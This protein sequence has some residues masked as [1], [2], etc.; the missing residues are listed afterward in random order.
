MADDLH[1]F[2]V[3]TDQSNEAE[4]K[5][6]LHL[7]TLLLPKGNRDTVEVL[8]V[9]L[10]WVASFAHVDEETGN[11]MDLHNLATVISPNIFRSYATKGNDN[12][13]VESFEGIRVC[14][15]LLIYQ[16]EF[17]LVPE[18]F[19]P[20]IRDV[21]FFVNYAELPSKEFLK[22]CDQ[23]L[24]V[25]GGSN[26]NSN[27]RSAGTSQ[28][29]LTSPI[30]GSA[31]F[32][33]SASMSSMGSESSR[34]TSQKSDP[35]MSSRGR[36]LVEAAPVARAPAN[37]ASM[38][39]Y[40]G[41]VPQALERSATPQDLYPRNGGGSASPRQQSPPPRAQNQAFTHPP[42]GQPP[43][44]FQQSMAGIAGVGTSGPRPASP[45]G[46]GM[47]PSQDPEWTAQIAQQQQQQQQQWHM[48]MQQQPGPPQPP[49]LPQSM[50][51]TYTPRNSGEHS[52]FAPPNG[53]TPVQV[54][55]RT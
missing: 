34:L 1:C 23:Y 39:G 38:N 14:D 44:S 22:R 10:K 33:P 50:S 12:V 26:A 4:K 32:V 25:K 27:G 20:M 37:M 41:P 18:E 13:R 29:G 43:A 2:H 54:R 53:H 45:M 19:L 47:P 9:F 3:G 5:R 51:S 24:R 52:H 35:A 6:L 55:Q 42:M 8:F 28:P 31:P 7:V 40:Y 16:D 17:F 46:M 48:Q 11:K 49:T 15:T 21:D 36:Q 30:I